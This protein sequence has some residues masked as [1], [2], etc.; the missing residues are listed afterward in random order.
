MLYGPENLEYTVGHPGVT[1]PALLTIPLYCVE[2]GEG[3][4]LCI[5]YTIL[6]ILRIKW[7]TKYQYVLYCIL[8][9]RRDQGT[10]H[11]HYQGVSLRQYHYWLSLCCQQAVH[12]HQ[13]IK[14]HVKTV[15]RTHSSR[16]SWR[17]IRVR[18]HGIRRHILDMGR[19]FPT[20]RG[21]GR[22]SASRIRLVVDNR[23][24]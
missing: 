21:T 13:A 20:W 7:L 16:G 14:T 6:C 8:V 5:L 11:Q 18:G 17:E 15:S 10:W 22:G 2:R 12:Q 3:P 23:V 19:G 4:L 24:D 9:N 1:L